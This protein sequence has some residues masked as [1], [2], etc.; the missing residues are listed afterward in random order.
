VSERERDPGGL[1]SAIYARM[2]EISFRSGAVA[3]GG[4]VAVGGLAIAL[5]V[6]PGEHHAAATGTAAAAPRSAVPIS[7]TIIPAVTPP[8]RTH[9][10]PAVRGSIPAAA[11][12]PYAAAPEQSVSPTRSAVTT[13]PPS[14]SPGSPVPPAARDRRPGARAPHGRPWYAPPW[15]AHGR[16]HKTGGSHRRPPWVV[17]SGDVDYQ[18]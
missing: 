4:V 12:A 9:H 15:Q 16:H 10:R 3:A 2:E 8:A 11:P 14:S 17:N 5:A 13:A 18:Q 6:L 1:K 7:P